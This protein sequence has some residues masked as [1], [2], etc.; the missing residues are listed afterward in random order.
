MP[1]RRD[2]LAAGIAA[3]T[4]LP[5]GVTLAQ[6]PA[7]PAPAAA[8]SLPYRPHAIRTPD[9]L[10]LAAYEYGNP[11]GPAILFVHG[12]AQAALSWDRQ[13]TDPAM[14]RDFRMVALDLRGHGMSDKPI[15]D[16]HY[17]TSKLWADDITATIEQAQL[18]R[19]TLVGWSYGGRVMGDDVN[20]HGTG[21]LGAMNWVAAVSS[22]AEPT[23]FGRGGRFIGP[24]TS[25]DPAIA[26]RGTVA[27]LRECFEIQPGA[28][29]FEV[30]LAFN[31]MVPRHVR[32]SLTGRQVG[33]EARLAALDLPVLVTQGTLDKLIDVT[34]GRHTAAIVPG[35]RLS[36]YVNI[37]HAPFWEDA[38]RFNRELA[39]LA[40]TARR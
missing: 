19:P 7:S 34:M 1:S 31:M 11:Q 12:Y 4:I 20:E 9:G 17:R 38:P 35:A 28:S 24:M 16:A 40:R 32:L 37:G 14:A 29:D 30:M 33:F 2:T 27:F 22:G 10:T 25:P 8:P 36:E 6:A 5:G 15:G 26:I 13:V 3:A 23:R 39:E 18:N 21:A